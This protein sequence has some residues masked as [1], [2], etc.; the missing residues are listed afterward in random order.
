VEVLTGLPSTPAAAWSADL[1]AVQAG[2]D[3]LAVSDDATAVLY[4]AARQPSQVWLATAD[5]GQSFVLGL[6]AAPRVAFLIQSEDAA[7]ADSLTGDVFLVR[8]LKSAPIVARL[9]GAEEGVSSP[10]AISAEPGN[11]RVFVANRQPGGV[12]GLALD[13]GEALRIDCPFAPTALERMESGSVFRLNEPGR[14]PLWILRTAGSAPGVVFVPDR[15]AG[16]RGSGRT[17][18]QRPDGGLR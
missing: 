3:A 8:H 1:P 17:P 15:R 5:A 10:A 18:I 4:A 16:V 14:G 7:I 6:A 2:L 11:R 9:G 12:V 13:G